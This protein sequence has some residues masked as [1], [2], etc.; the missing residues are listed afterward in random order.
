MSPEPLQILVS[1]ADLHALAPEM[2]VCGAAFALLMID[3]FLSPQRRGLTHFLAI[4]VL[5]GAAVLTAR[6]M[7]VGRVLAFGGMFVRDTAADVLKMGTYG[8]TT[9][10]FVYAKPYLQDRG[11]FKGE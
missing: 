11:L 2:F 6:D 1:R 8:V 10:V 3:L 4:F 7:A 5:V 9:L